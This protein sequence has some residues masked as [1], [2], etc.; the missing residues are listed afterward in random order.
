[1][2]IK[3]RIKLIFTSRS[4]LNARIINLE[5]R[6]QRERD[7]A[8]AAAR[9]VRELHIENEHLIKTLKDNDQKA[10]HYLNL[11]DYICDVFWLTKYHLDNWDLWI[12]WDKWL[13][14]EIIKA[15]KNLSK[16][17]SKE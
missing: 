5:G 2:N 14:D 8:A 7:Y 10:Q 3:D 15:R 9:Y 13:I 11:I 1:M 4:K 17:K 6:I 12:A 16:K